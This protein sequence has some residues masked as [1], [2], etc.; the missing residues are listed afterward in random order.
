MP[1]SSDWL[2]LIENCIILTFYKLYLLILILKCSDASLSDEGAALG[3]TEKAKKRK[4]FILILPFL[5][6]ELNSTWVSVVEKSLYFKSRESK[7]TGLN[8]LIEH[9]LENQLLNKHLIFLTELILS[10]AICI[11]KMYVLNVYVYLQ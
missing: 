2:E 1:Y 3:Y 4:A 5:R 11:N 10:M 7:H 9:Y 6:F 8:R